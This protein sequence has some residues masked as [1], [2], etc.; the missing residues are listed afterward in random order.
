MY[1]TGVGELMIVQVYLSIRSLLWIY[2]R[3]AILEVGLA[4]QP[5][6]FERKSAQ[7]ERNGPDHSKRKESSYDKDTSS[8]GVKDL[9]DR[10]QNV[11][12][13]IAKGAES[14]Q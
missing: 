8:H 9:S 10:A 6:R 3:S 7:H 5:H 12:V 4:T 14:S 13:E 11:L 1:A 2:V